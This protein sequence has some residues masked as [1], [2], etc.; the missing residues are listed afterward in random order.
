MLSFAQREKTEGCIK[1]EVKCKNCWKY[2]FEMKKVQM[3]SVEI[4]MHNICNLKK[5]LKFFSKF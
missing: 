2:K 4:G 1:G 3:N 5:I